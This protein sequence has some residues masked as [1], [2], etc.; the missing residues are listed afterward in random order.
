MSKIYSV[1]SAFFAIILALPLVIAQ[2]LKHAE[3]GYEW[4][5]PRD[6][7]AHDQYQTEWWYYTGHLFSKEAKLFEDKPLYGFQLT[8][9]RRSDRK[10]GKIISEY[11]AHAALTDI[12][13]QKTYHAK[14][15]GG[16]ALGI[17]SV[18]N[19]SLAAHSGD[20]TIDS[21]GNR[22]FAR[23]AVRDGER[24]FDLELRVLSED[25][26]PP[27]LQGELGLSKKAACQSCASMYYSMPRIAVSATLRE[28]AGKL[29][30]LSGL[31]WMDHEFMTNSLSSDQVGWDW[32]GL[33]L[34]D[35]RS[36]MLF[37]LR[38]KNGVQDFASG[39]I[40]SLT[41][42][43]A[44]SASDFEITPLVNWKSAASGADY[45]IQ[46][47]VVV[48]SEGIDAVLKARVNQCEVGGGLDDQSA[49]GV[50]YW[51]GPVTSEDEGIFG[52]LEMTGYVGKVGV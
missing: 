12:S 45:P 42:T 49:H 11:M 50:K 18:A 32:F 6:H 9:F 1:L 25:L 16:G 20:W 39:G 33:N 31:V 28:G 14:R 35:G 7:G 15:V 46:W 44:L 38:N 3:K 10:S 2:E 22:F 36:L 24:G 34:K 30:D 37:R 19:D 13:K 4:S 8:F 51:E 41:G 23:F 40:R 48:P 29:R 21:V 52:Y 5:F 17:S 43:R 27:W 47:R 26:S